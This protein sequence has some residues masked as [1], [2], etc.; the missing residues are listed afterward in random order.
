[1]C[2][3]TQRVKGRDA[4]PLSVSCW[5]IDKLFELWQVELGLCSSLVPFLQ[6]NAR[7]GL[8]DTP[9]GS[10]VPTIASCIHASLKII[11]N[12][13]P[14]VPCGWVVAADRGNKGSLMTL[15]RRVAATGPESVLA[16]TRNKMGR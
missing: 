2:G 16:K 4:I 15:P 11:M 9:V 7:L 3:H 5:V 8:S 1:M 13:F 10:M 14:T 6:V 12:I